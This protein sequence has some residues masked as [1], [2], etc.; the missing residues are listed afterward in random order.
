MDLFKEHKYFLNYG[1][2]Y[3]CEHFLEL[4]EHFLRKGEHFSIYMNIILI[5][6]NFS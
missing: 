2:L 5:R 3:V 4:H 6:E 1:Y